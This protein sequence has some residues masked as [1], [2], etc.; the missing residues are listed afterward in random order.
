[1][2]TE[3]FDWNSEDA[4]N[5]IEAPGP[6]SWPI[7]L[8]CGITLLIAGLVTS[9]AVSVLGGIVSIAGAVGW[10]RDVLPHERRELVRVV[11]QVPGV[12][13]TRREVARMEIARESRRAWL[14]VEIHPISAGVKGGLAGS[15]AMAILAVLYGDS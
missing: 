4:Q 15:A 8:A 5:T 10:F 3:P 6:T 1:M 12:K 9:E 14:P 7:V 2:T 13:T 11:M